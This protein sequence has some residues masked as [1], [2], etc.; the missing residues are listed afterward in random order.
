MMTTFKRGKSSLLRILAVIPIVVATILIFGSVHAKPKQEVTEPVIIDSFDIKSTI[1]IRDGGKEILLN[2]EP[3]TLQ[4]LGEAVKQTIDKV[5][6]ISAEN[7]V[8]MGTV[9]DVKETLRES[10]VTK[11]NYSRAD[12]EVDQNDISVTISSDTQPEEVAEIKEALRESGV[13]KVNYR[14]AESKPET[15]TKTVKARNILIVDVKA[16]GSV[17]V[18]GEQFTN[19]NKLKREVKRFIHNFRLATINTRVLRIVKI[20]GGRQYEKNSE[21]TTTAVKM[22]EGVHMACPVSKGIVSINS[23][24]PMGSPALESVS[25]TIYEAFMELREKMAHRI[26]G[27]SYDKIDEAQKAEIDKVV[28][29]NIS[30]ALK[31]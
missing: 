27:K 29:I 12:G 2:D 19:E 1:Q 24:L 25:N 28:P 21:F 7:D 13:T 9:A 3:V 30:L 14:K 4:Q 10:G 17:F 5:V 22:G 15:T 18:R 23:E 11:V 16:D 6:T 8:P 26:Y 20:S 31:E